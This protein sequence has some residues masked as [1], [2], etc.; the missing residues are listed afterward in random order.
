MSAT[1]DIP[2]SETEIMRFII[3]QEDSTQSGARKI[4]LKEKVL[5]YQTSSL[6]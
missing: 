5:Y 4:K 6:G 3:G 1:L 2:C